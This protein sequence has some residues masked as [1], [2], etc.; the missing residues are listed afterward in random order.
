MTN[1]LILSQLIST[2]TRITE[3]STTLID[4]IYTSQD[5]NYTDTNTLDLG[6]SDHSLIYT[7]R[8]NTKNFSNVKSHRKTLT[9]WK[10]KDTDTANF[11]NEL[12]L[13]TWDHIYLTPH[14]DAM[15]TSFNDTLQSILSHY[16][17]PKRRFV[18]STNL[19]PWLDEEVRA[20][21]LQY[22]DLYRIVS[23]I[24]YGK[25]RRL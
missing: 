15:L 16:T 8:K 18:K 24:A 6:L 22:I 23:N 14:P 17:Q 25:N 2:P 19:P 3:H 9:Y 20:R 11:L 12:S 1:N 4:H 21:L 13:T 5:H 10:W 7:I